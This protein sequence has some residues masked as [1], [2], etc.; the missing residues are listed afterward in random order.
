ML[1]GTVLTL[2]SST[3]A[4]P[5]AYL[6]KTSFD[7]WIPQGDLRRL[8]YAGLGLLSLK[9]VTSGLSVAARAVNV[10]STQAAT[11]QLRKT[12]NERLYQVSRREFDNGTPGDFYDNFVVETRR[13]E[14]VANFV[15]GM[16]VPA[17]FRGVALSLILAYLSWKLLGVLMLAWP[18]L[19]IC[20]EAVRRYCLEYT[21]RNHD[22]FR[23]FGRT[24]GERIRLLNLIRY[25]NTEEAEKR[26]IERQMILAEKTSRPVAVL[27]T[28]YLESQAVVLAFVSVAV[29]MA[30]GYEVST[31]HMTMGDFVAF[32]TVVSLLNSALRSFATATYHVFTGI[33]SV[34]TLTRWLNS[35]D[36]EVYRGS[37]KLQLSRE[38]R[39]RDVEFCYSPDEPLIKRLN[40]RLKH[41]ETT[42]L[43]GANGSG[44]STILWLLLGLY[45]TGGGFIEADGEKYEELDMGHLRAQ[46]GVVPQEALL[47]DASIR[48]N[49]RYSRP[50]ATDEE[51][52]KSLELSG[53]GEWIRS[54]PDGLDTRVGQGGALLSGGQRQRLSLARA[55]LKRPSFL[56]LDEPTNH[57]DEGAV[58][59]FLQ[60]L[61]TL[62]PAPG[63]LIITHDN[64]MKEVA[65]VIYQLESGRVVQFCESR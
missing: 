11:L 45:R 21:N 43:M 60:T 17:V 65:D 20:N 63:I 51:I 49:V 9:I 46:F 44:K 23:R 48:E 50:Q 54:L 36:S 19:W 25:E 1:L 8:F 56:V 2:V 22:V 15:S 32:Y 33:E 3:M 38:V 27:E 30:G 14:A 28:A 47:L 24:V 40:M 10:R 34:D 41:G 62:E 55:L 12:L 29:L 16:L 4:L 13:L 53:S 52:V 18:V 7:I 5:M 6:V 26:E 35:V 37:R 61:R 31:G 64:A 57:L 58:A 59:A 42:V 39:F